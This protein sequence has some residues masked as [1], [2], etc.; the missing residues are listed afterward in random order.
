MNLKDYKKKKKKRGSFK[1]FFFVFFFLF[2][3]N[4]C[5]TVDS[6]DKMGRTHRYGDITSQ[7]LRFNK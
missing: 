6:D 3:K 5:K 7:K 1:V 2:G 4:S